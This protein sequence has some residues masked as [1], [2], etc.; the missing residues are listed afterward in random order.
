MYPPDNKFR[1]MNLLL[2]ATCIIISSKHPPSPPT[3]PVWLLVNPGS[4]PAITSQHKN[5]GCSSN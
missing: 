5:V 2:V 3:H 4:E 1:V